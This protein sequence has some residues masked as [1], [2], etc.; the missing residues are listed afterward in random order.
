MSLAQFV[1]AS[2]LLL[3]TSVLI[4]SASAV[5]PDNDARAK[6]FVEY[7]EA[8]VRPQECAA[9]RCFWNA[10]VTGKE[11][12]F[13]KKQAAEEKVDLLLADPQ[14]FAELKAIHE[15]AISDRLLAREIQVLYLEYLAKQVDHELLM[16][17]LAKSNVVERAFNVFR[18]EVGGKK[19]TDND[20]R[21]TLRES[22]DSA[23]LQ[24]TWEA[25]KKAGPAVVGDLLALVRL[26]NQAARKL[27]FKNYAV[28]H[29][30]CSEQSPEELLKLFDQL[31]ELTRGPFHEAKAEIDAALA[32]DCGIAV[33]ELRPWHYRDPFFQE[34]P[35]VAGGLP[36]SVYKPMDSVKT[37][38][39][40]YAGIG[41][42]IDEVLK[43][44]DLYERPG[45]NPH[46][47]S[48]DID[49]AGDIRVLENFVPGQEW[50]R[51]SLHEL[52]HSAYSENV[53]H[54][55][56]CA[57]HRRP[58][59]LHRGRGH[60]VRAIC[61]ERRL[62]DSD[63]GE[64][65]RSREIPPGRGQV[66]AKPAAGLFAVLPGDVPLRDGDVRATLSR[67]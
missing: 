38:R 4:N 33:T 5:E 26:R 67:T 44:S 65:S 54:F 64:H 1:V 19:L 59:A 55:A 13:Q 47:F 30:Y 2:G 24:A 52:G 28:L 58:S 14:K 11:E 40:F 50:L 49:R 56:L 27:G 36:D 10:N 66:A 51:T 22:R 20:I 43:R 61:A 34:A 16:K 17:M 29:L 18:P 37:V 62:A 42:P 39:D 7:F 53:G 25:S 48:I 63:G 41:L 46:A 57:A 12:D 45:K 8:T 35:V 23:E 31:D 9:A 15:G 6:R 60:D 3:L 32:R 21:R